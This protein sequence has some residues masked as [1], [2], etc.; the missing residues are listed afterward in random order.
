MPG[1]AQAAPAAAAGAPQAWPPHP[2]GWRPRQ[3]LPPPLP[4]QRQLL[5]AVPLHLFPLLLLG[6]AGRP[7][8]GWPLPAAPQARTQPCTSII[9]RQQPMVGRAKAAVACHASRSL[10]KAIANAGSSQLLGNPCVPGVGSP[11]AHPPALYELSVPWPSWPYWGQPALHSFP[12]HIHTVKSTPQPTL[13]HL[14]MSA[15]RAEAEA[16]AGTGQMIGQRV[17]GGQGSAVQRKSGANQTAGTPSASG[18]P[19]PASTPCQ[20]RAE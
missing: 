8:V 6:G 12:S 19:N 13:A 1:S 9:A 2:L 10:N 11:P 5:P 18:P 4:P 20:T 3:Q 15:C 7:E 17:V 16:E 14:E